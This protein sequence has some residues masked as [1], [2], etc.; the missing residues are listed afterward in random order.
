[1]T[2]QAIRTLV[3]DDVDDLRF[4]VR[5]AL[6]HSRDF[7]VV[8]EAADGVQAV[9]KAAELRPDLVLLD[10][11][12]P[13][14][15]GLEALPKI[16]EVVPE[17]KVI[18]LSGFQAQRLAATAMSL[19]AIGYVEKGVPPRR[20]V[21]ELFEMV[22]DGPADGGGRIVHASPSPLSDEPM[23]VSSQVDVEDL[24][25]FV[26]HEIRNP[27]TVVQGLASALETSWQRLD[28]EQISDI[29]RRI[30]VNSS[31]L[32]GVV[33]SIFLLGSQST[34]LMLEWVTNDVES[35]M[36]EI[37]GHLRDVAAEHPLTTEIL[38]GLPPVQVDPARFRQVLTNLVVNAAKFSPRGAPIT[39]RARRDL[40]SVIV[41]VIDEGPG[42]PPD[43]VGS[44]FHK[45]TRFHEGQ[46]GLGIG[47][48]I[49]RQLMNAMGG[50]IWIKNSSRGAVVACRL[51]AVI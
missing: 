6:E 11:S 41:E 15:D 8:G 37:T 23:E 32:D 5:M 18:M 45:F 46:S 42:F 48:Y 7:E 28:G 31:Y 43:R 29:A 4:L 26:A 44:A 12:M 16:R 25:S 17:A 34:D 2:T 24:L 14:E 39:I 20:L 36:K 30:V 49:S 9:V 51:P 10:I 3:V 21:R 19:G 1:M 50:E 35:M 33:K 13:V 40:Q 22:R 27:L 38:P 47:L